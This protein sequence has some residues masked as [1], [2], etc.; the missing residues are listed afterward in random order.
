MFSFFSA[1]TRKWPPSTDTVSKKLPSQMK[2]ELF[3]SPRK[4]RLWFSHTSA[5]ECDFTAIICL[6]NHRP[7]SKGRFDSIFW[8]WSLIAQC[9]KSPLNWLSINLTASTTLCNLLIF[10]SS[11]AFN[12]KCAH[13]KLQK[14]DNCICK[15]MVIR[16]PAQNL[17]GYS[18]R[19]YCKLPI[20]LYSFYSL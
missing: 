12:A 1:Y 9:R 19:V 20:L 18:K 7:F 11:S 15:N 14:G 17:D 3:D 5:F 13:T 8:Y 4:F 6:S 10:T 16:I 2:N